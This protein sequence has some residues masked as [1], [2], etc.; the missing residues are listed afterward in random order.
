[1]GL[2]EERQGNANEIKFKGSKL[3]TCK[4]CFVLFLK[5]EKL[6]I[7]VFTSVILGFTVGMSINTTVQNM[8]EPDRTTLLILLGFPGELLVRMLRML[9]LPLIVCSLIVGLAGL[10]QH[11]SGRVGRRAIIYYL[12]TTLIAAILGLLIVVAIQPGSKAAANNEMPLKH[13]PKA[14]TLDS[15]LDL[16]RN[17]FPDNII[18]ACIEQARTTAIPMQILVKSETIDIANMNSSQLEEIKKKYKLITVMKNK[19]SGENKTYYNIYKNAT[20]AGPLEYRSG[21]NL[22]GL[23]VFAIAVGLVTA[24]LGESGKL[25]LTVVDTINKVVSKLVQYVMWYSPIGI[26]SLL[27]VSF[28]QMKDISATFESLGMLV[29]C[30]MLG[31]CIH[32]LII[33]PG[34]YFIILRRNP[35]PYFKGIA[36]ALITAFGTSS[37]A[38]TLP[39][40]IKC[41]E[42]KQ[43]VDNRIVRFMVPI[44]ATVNMDGGAL[45]E[46]LA[47]IYLAQVYGYDLDFG[48]YIAISLAATMAS[49]GSAGVPSVAPVAILIVLQAAGLPP[50]AVSLIFSVDWFLDRFRTAV[51]VC[52][53]CFGAAVVEHLSREDLRLSDNQKS[54]FNNENE[55]QEL[56][57]APSGLSL[58]SSH[59]TML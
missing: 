41:L 50:E 57:S 3:D 44:G 9:V 25:F 27:T 39:V 38:A 30:V 46:A 43:N 47:C 48:K 16:L 24:S 11:A 31:L 54:C 8:Q 32:V 10:E 55:S 17:M 21:Q 36:Q 1:M 58:E 56:Q 13:Q 35:Y 15:F 6:I 14:R 42:E 49:I 7:A 19:T 2:L 59:V 51:N 12:G 23:V 37:S 20:K 52:G 18:Q 22:I 26:W 45:Y 40:T 33:Y 53:D 4:G 5:R 28:A 29:L 34:I